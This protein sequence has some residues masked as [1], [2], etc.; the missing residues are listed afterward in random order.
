MIER[1]S[2]IASARDCDPQAE[3][4]FPD[5]VHVPRLLSTRPCR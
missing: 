3:L 1:H 5:V 2:S 4:R